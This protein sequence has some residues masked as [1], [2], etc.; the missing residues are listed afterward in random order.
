MVVVL[1]HNEGG[2]VHV[3]HP[4]GHVGDVVVG[5]LSGD[6]VDQH[7]A[8]DVPAAE[9][10]DGLDDPGGNPPGLALLINFKLGGVKHIGGVLEAQVAHDIPVERLREGVFHPLL[11]PHHAGL[12]GDHV[13]QHIGGQALAPVGE[14]LDEVGVVDGGHTHRPTLVVDLGGVV[15]VLKLADHVTE[16]THLTVAQVL[17]A[18]PVQ[19]GDLVEGDL[20]DVLGKVS[21]L[22]RQ[23]IPVGARPED[24]QG[25]ELAHQSHHNNGHKQDAHRHTAAFH[26]A[27]P[28]TGLFL[29]GADHI[30]GVAAGE[31]E[32][33]DH[34]DDAQKGEEAVEF[35]GLKIQCGQRD[36]EVEEAYDGRDDNAEQCAA[37]TALGQVTAF[38]WL[39]GI[40]DNSPSFP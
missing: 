4:G 19:G 5:A 33:A 8:L 14:P 22:H 3:V 9:Q 31:Q 16:G 21:V 17:G 12:L 25:D 13:H 35:A 1:L 37:Q 10:A 7:R 27:E 39:V 24:G 36:I 32:N 34:V 28:L 6:G 26:K 38:V 11:E 23:Q 30:V 15:G 29:G 18:V 40:Q 2:G 20:G